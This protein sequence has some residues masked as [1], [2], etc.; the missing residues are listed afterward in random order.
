MTGAIDQVGNILPIGAVNEKIEGFFDVCHD[1][2]LTGS[3]GV[4][5]PQ[6]N[7]S[8]LMLRQD[9]LQACERDQFRVYAVNTVEEALEVMTGQAAGKRAA[10]L[11]VQRTQESD[12]GGTGPVLTPHPP[13]WTGNR[14]PFPCKRPA[15]A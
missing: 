9:V 1:L 13:P 3:Q 7:A 2:G 14:L 5:I 12:P 6:A 11:L 4:I 15:D 10:D 8:N